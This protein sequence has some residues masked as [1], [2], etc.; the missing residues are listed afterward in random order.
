[1]GTNG[2]VTFANTTDTF[3]PQGTVSWQPTAA[4]FYGS[5]ASHLIFQDADG[6]TVLELGVAAGTSINLDAHYFIGLRPW[7]CPVKAQTL[8][9][10]SKLR[11]M[12]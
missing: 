4:D 7:K 2:V 8:T 9:A 1:M 6:V 11:L 12:M 10:G 5:A 3:T